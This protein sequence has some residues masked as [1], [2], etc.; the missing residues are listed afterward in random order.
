[1][2]G[3]SAAAA[4][5]LVGRPEV[6]AAAEAGSSE[7]VAAAPVGHPEADLPAGGDLTRPLYSSNTKQ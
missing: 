1:M 3:S 4:A 6:V 7:A 5:A 2:A